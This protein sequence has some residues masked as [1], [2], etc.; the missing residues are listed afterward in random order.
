MESSLYRELKL[1][2]KMS[3]GLGVIGNG[4]FMRNQQGSFTL[5]MKEFDKNRE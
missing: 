5:A 3:T 1:K 4:T 2:I